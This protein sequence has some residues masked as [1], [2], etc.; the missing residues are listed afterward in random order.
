MGCDH[1]GKNSLWSRGIVGGIDEGYAQLRDAPPLERPSSSP[2]R[3]SSPHRREHS[4][5]I[6]T[7]FPLS[8]VFGSTMNTVWGVIFRIHATTDIIRATSFI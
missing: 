1:P 2:P 6:R 3:F 4:L 7:F 5:L 8:P